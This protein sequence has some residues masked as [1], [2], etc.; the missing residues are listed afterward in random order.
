MAYC[1]VRSA[2]SEQAV[3]GYHHIRAILGPGA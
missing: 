1:E 2:G 3:T